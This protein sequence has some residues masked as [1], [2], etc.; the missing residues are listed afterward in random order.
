M[1]HGRVLNRSLFAKHL[2]FVVV[3]A[4]C[5]FAVAVDDRGLALQVQRLH[6]MRLYRGSSMAMV[7][8][9]EL[10]SMLM[11]SVTMDWP[12]VD[13]EWLPVLVDTMTVTSKLNKKEKTKLI[14]N[15]FNIFD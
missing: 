5:P 13:V 12:H 3:V 7:D 9:V 11:S 2:A 6:S 10:C 15:L 14:S 8:E 4:S 1:A